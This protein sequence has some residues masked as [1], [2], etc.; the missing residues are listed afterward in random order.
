MLKDGVVPQRV[1]GLEDPQAD[2]TGVAGAVHVHGL[3][4]ENMYLDKA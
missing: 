1:L 2:G 4:I 3:G